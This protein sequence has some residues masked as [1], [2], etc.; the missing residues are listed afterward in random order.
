MAYEDKSGAQ[1]VFNASKEIRLL[2][3]SAVT[4]EDSLATL[5]CTLHYVDRE[6]RPTY[7]AISYTWGEGPANTNEVICNGCPLLVGNNCYT[8]LCELRRLKLTGHENLIWMDALCINQADVG[9]RNAQVA[10]M[11]DTFRSA[12]KTIVFLRQDIIEDSSPFPT[13]YVNMS[14]RPLSPD[15]DLKKS[16]M[17]NPWYRPTGGHSTSTDIYQRVW[18]GRGDRSKDVQLRMSTLTTNPWFTRTWIVQELMLSREPSLLMEGD[19]CLVPWKILDQ[20]YAI[21]SPVSCET[22]QVVTMHAG[23]TA[24]GIDAF[25]DGVRVANSEDPGQEKATYLR[26][27]FATLVRTRKFRCT[28]PRD[29]LYGILALFSMTHLETLQPDYNK[30]ALTVYSDLIWSMLES[31]ITDILALAGLHANEVWPS[32]VVDW[33]IDPRFCRDKL[34]ERPSQYKA[35][36][37]GGRGRLHVSRS[38]D[39]RTLVVRGLMVGHVQSDYLA[40]LASDQ[41]SSLGTRQYPACVEDLVRI[42]LGCSMPFVLRKDGDRLRLVDE[43]RISGYMK[44]E[45]LAHLDASSC[46]GV[47]PP[48]GLQ[49]FE[50]H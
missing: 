27:L 48:P 47:T 32:W 19:A 10:R 23:W 45:A 40:V 46:Y 28:D 35:G 26:R 11:G 49:D 39:G 18:F 25:V 31:G 38:D 33:S 41:I 16:D 20:M 9:E 2:T 7:T 4:N 36:F 1:P 5:R 42:L 21:W 15:P 30:S 13:D 3:I 22:P 50:I 43:C 17:H 24:T 6:T 8:L 29:K 12:A 37:V 14:Y 34:I 44:G